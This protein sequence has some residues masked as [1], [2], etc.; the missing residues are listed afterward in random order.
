MSTIEATQAAQATQT[1]S[2]TSKIV[3]E[4][5]TLG[6]TKTQTFTLAELNITQAMIDGDDFD[7]GVTIE[8]DLF[9]WA[10][11]NVDHRFSLMKPLNE[12]TRNTQVK[13]EL[14]INGKPGNPKFYELGEIVDTQMPIKNARLKAV[15]EHL[16]EDALVNY[17]NDNVFYEW[18]LAS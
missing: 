14:L 15:V 11:D 5:F 2:P 16:I 7:L 4:V 10:Y 1:L 13:F 9:N 6:M 12:A 17:R 8:D 3:F 18:R